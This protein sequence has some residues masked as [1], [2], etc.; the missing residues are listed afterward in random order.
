MKRKILILEFSEFD[1]ELI[2]GELMSLSFEVETKVVF[3]KN[4][5][6]V[7]VR[8]WKPDLVISAYHLDNY[9]GS[10]ALLYVKEASQNT[11]VIIIS[12]SII[13]KVQINLLE[14]RANDVLTKQDLK[15][16]SFTVGRV[17]NEADDKRKLQDTLSLLSVNL[18]FQEI[19]AEISLNFNST[20]SFEAKMHF[21]ISILGTAAGVSRVYIFENIGKGK[22]CR[23]TFEWC[24]DGINPQINKL[25]NVLYSSM[26]S[27]KKIIKMEGRVFAE[28]VSKLPKD[29][30]NIMIPLGVKAVLCYPLYVGDEYFGFIGFDE[31][32]EIRNWNKSTDKL[33]KTVSGT[34]SNA[35][36]EELAKRELQETN[37]QLI[38]LIKEK[39][40][41]IGEVHHRVKNNL[42]L[43]SS[44][45][46][47][48][49]MGLGVSDSETI[50]SSNILRIKS[51]AIIHELVYEQGSFSDIDVY[52]TLNKV[53][54]ESHK[55]EGLLDFKVLRM[56]DNEEIK[57]NINQA[58]PFSLLVGEMIF[59]AFRAEGSL[60]YEPP[61]EFKIHLSKNK[62]YVRIGF[63]EESLAR[64]LAVFKKKEEYKFTEI[65]EVL[66]KQ[67]DA[68]LT[69]E[70]DLSSAFLEFEY[71]DIHGSS[72]ALKN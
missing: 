32:K 21:A 54:V 16:L 1:A 13:Q 42:A 22:A 44:F 37:E 20:D 49:Q 72:S 58:V 57:F 23:N 62:R 31:T 10:E 70:D 36:G 24:A 59:E 61:S 67:I 63:L 46:Q 66:S 41:L 28:D 51:I 38:A 26:P 2:L 5:F 4:I 39:E 29:L 69:V 55:Q 11:P 68:T 9:N 7:E 35:Y 8:E 52:S 64:I 27:W 6:E 43:I 45:L 48:D 50:I 40:S 3:S 65:L 34:I 71:R 15:K 56:D 18:R 33:L 47:L 25:Q 19:L 53:L 30:A 17:L 14:N 12:G 60:I